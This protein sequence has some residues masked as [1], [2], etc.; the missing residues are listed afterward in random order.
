MYVVF[1]LVLGTLTAFGPICTDLY[2]P[3]LPSITQAFNS[4][5]SLMSLTLTSSFLGLAIGQIIIGPISDAKGRK[6]PL[7]ISLWIFIISSLL[8][9]STNNLVLF[10]IYR[11]FQGLSGAG[12]L[13]LSRAIACDIYKGSKLSA[14]MSLLMVINSIAPIIGPVLG[15]L[16]ITFFAWHYIFIVL[17]LLG[18]ILLILSTFTIKETLSFKDRKATLLKSL[19]SMLQELLNLKFLYM[20]LAMGF[21]MAGF[22]AYLAS[23]PF[24]IQKIY[25]ISPLLYSVIFSINALSITFTAQFARRLSPKIGDRKILY[26]AY[27][28]LFVAS[29]VML[30]IAFINPKNPLFAIITILVSVSMVGLTQGPG[31]ALSMEAKK[32]GFGSASGIFGVVIFIFA[33]I[34]SSLSSLDGDMSMR[35]LA[36]I[37]FTG[38][39][40]SLLLFYLS[41]KIKN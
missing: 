25:N 13:V 12:G 3:A 10:I 2:L 34:S 38:V 7:L 31:F 22:F 9:A 37:M 6:G 39:I 8:C 1:I 11:F 26:I 32:G 29:V 23:S 5:A 15:S 17:A 40:L 28:I 27:V 20:V 24:I 41:L 18:L 14:F 16:I 30:F 4:N 19:K 35:P 21:I 33:A 36:I